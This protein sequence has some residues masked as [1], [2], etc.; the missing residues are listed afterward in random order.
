[1]KTFWAIFIATFPFMAGLWLLI[2]AIIIVLFCKAI[3][4]PT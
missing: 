1:M 4:V 3:G 2:A